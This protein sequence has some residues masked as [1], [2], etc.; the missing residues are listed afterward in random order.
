ME[1]TAQ[2]LPGLRGAVEFINF[3]RKCS[4]LDTEA[5]S[6]LQDA[7]AFAFHADV[8]RDGIVSEP[9]VALLND[10]AFSQK[11]ECAIQQNIPEL[12]PRIAT[13]RTRLVALARPKL[14]AL[15]EVI[16]SSGPQGGVFDSDSPSPFLITFPGC[17]SWGGS[18]PFTSP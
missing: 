5:I 12:F 15:R 10:P 4:E 6:K 8:T 16:D 17:I 2:L 18:G 9:L 1:D 11:L 7:E 3:A 13:L 14:E